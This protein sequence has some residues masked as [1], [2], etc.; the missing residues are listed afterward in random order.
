MKLLAVETELKLIGDEVKTDLLKEEAVI[1]LDLHNN[2]FIK[3]IYFN[4]EHCA[5]IILEC[6]SMESAKD[7]LS[8]LPLVRKGYISFKIMELNPYTGF[9]R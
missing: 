9:E 1:V 5:V 4:D 7:A 2:G 8:K 3:E 6:E